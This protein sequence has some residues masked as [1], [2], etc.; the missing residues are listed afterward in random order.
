MEVPEDLPGGFFL[1]AMETR[2]A[3][4]HY[5]AKPLKIYDIK[6]I[7]ECG[8]L[9]PS[10]FGLEPWTFWAISLREQI[11]ALGI[12]CFNQEAVSSA[13]LA[14]CILVERDE[15]FAPGSEFLKQRASRFPG[16]YPVFIEDYR[17]Y[18]KFLKSQ[19]RI[20][21]WS[22]SQAYLA[23]ANMMT[24]AKALG[25]DSC[26]IEGF[27]EGEV[28]KTLG[29]PQEEKA[30]GLIVVFGFGDESPREKIRESPADIIHRI[31]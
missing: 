7:L 15:A 13:A 14:V 23:A 11:E 12:A 5:S 26:A 18:Y 1:R 8:R 4:K 2:F 24:G 9:S 27:D 28:L 20:L 25:V 17:G 6:Y 30:V 31:S 10:S 29:I 21:S 19:D 16:G 3:C 22:M